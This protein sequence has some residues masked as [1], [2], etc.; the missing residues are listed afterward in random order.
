LYN[1]LILTDARL[2]LLIMDIQENPQRYINLSLIDF[3]GHKDKFRGDSTYIEQLIQH[4]TTL[5]KKMLPN[6]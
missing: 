5:S 1:E 4:D 2:N 3:R 6:K